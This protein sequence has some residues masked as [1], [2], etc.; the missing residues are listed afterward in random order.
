MAGRRLERVAEAIREVVGAA[1]L[2]AFHPDWT[3]RPLTGDADVA[4]GYRVTDGALE[5]AW[6]PNLGCA[7]T[8]AVDLAR[9]SRALEA[10]SVVSRE[11]YARMTTPARLSNG[12]DWPYGLGLGLLSFAGRPK[13]VHTGRVLGFYAVLAR[14]PADDLTIAIM[15]NL[16]GSSSIAYQLEPRIARL[17]LGVEE[18]HV[19][20]VPLDSEGMARFAGTYDAGAFC[21]E[22]V[23]D[24]TRIALI[25]RVPGD[26]NETDVYDRKDIA[27]PGWH[28]VH[29]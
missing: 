17:L 3:P 22:V 2:A 8:T 14:Y 6:E 16:G 7:W 27:V 23:P 12:R 18:P 20:D 28:C 13:I 11:S 5:V 1:G 10:G 24:G 21:F 29:R 15:S 26:Q 9:W 19:R 25:M 4:Q